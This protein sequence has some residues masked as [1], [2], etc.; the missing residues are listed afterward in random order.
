MRRRWQV[1]RFWIN[2]FIVAMTIKRRVE[3]RTWSSFRLKWLFCSDC[4]P[5]LLFNPLIRLFVDAAACDD[6]KL[7]L[8]TATLLAPPI[9]PKLVSILSVAYISIFIPQ[10]RSWGSTVLLLVLKHA[11]IHC[12][13]AL[14]FIINQPWL[15]QNICTTTISHYETPRPTL[16]SYFF[17]LHS[18]FN[19][20]ATVIIVM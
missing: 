9:D 2:V 13:L 5:R 6:D 19:I 20:M 1:Y 12:G 4:K 7:L 18:R 8:G 16:I 10:T 15:L 3:D 17:V 14:G 11:S